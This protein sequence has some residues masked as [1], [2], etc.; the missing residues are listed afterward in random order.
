MTE[1]RMQKA[2]E[3]LNRFYAD[4]MGRQV[5]YRYYGDRQPADQYFY[6]TEKINHK[7]SLKYTAGIY[8]YLKSKK[9]WKLVK[10][11]GFA[12]KKK[13]IEWARK[14]YEAKK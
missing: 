1:E 6:T 2:I 10:Q 5:N 9:S 4:M 12:K 13:A 11:V 14:T 3:V 8:R 7:G